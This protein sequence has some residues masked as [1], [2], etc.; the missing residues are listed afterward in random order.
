MP[1]TP[2]RVLIPV[3]A[4]DLA[5]SRIELVAP[6]RRSLAIAMLND[7]IAACAGVPEVHGVAVVTADDDAATWA[8]SSQAAVIRCPGVGLNHDLTTAMNEVAATSPELGIAIIV[9]DLPSLS[10]DDL[11]AVLHEAPSDSAA[12]VAG[13]DGGTTILLQPPGISIQPA[14]GIN[15]SASHRHVANELVSAPDALRCDVDSMDDLFE[16]ARVGVGGHTV[17]WLRE[18]RRASAPTRCTV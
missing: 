16:A 12:F 1:L 2:W 14:F 11:R 3:K 6:M 4:L 15:S 13:Q 5:K 10:T 9:A 7:V 18:M 8:R 17:A